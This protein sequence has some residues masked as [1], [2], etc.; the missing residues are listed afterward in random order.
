MHR[1]CAFV[2][3]DFE[4]AYSNHGSACAVGLVRVESGTIT[5]RYSHLIRPPRP[6]FEYSNVHGISWEDVV[7]AP[8]FREIWPDISEFISGVN[9]LAAHNAVFDRSVLHACCRNAK[10]IPPR[11]PFRCS[12]KIARKTWSVYPTTLSA[13]CRYLGISLDRHHD[14]LCDAEACAK[15][16]LAAGS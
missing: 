3:V 7:T 5:A 8:V 6:R 14:A 1:R 10:V 16:L 11:L 12:M 9:F 13:V 15:I 4:T 2:A